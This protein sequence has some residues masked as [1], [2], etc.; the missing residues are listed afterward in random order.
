MNCPLYLGY[1]SIEIGHSLKQTQEMINLLIESGVL[2]S[3]SLEEKKKSNINV[4]GIV[5]QLVEKAQISKADL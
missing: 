5:Y 2:K 4:E 3:L 1:V